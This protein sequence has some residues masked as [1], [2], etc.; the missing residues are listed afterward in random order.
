MVDYYCNMWIQQSEV[1]APLTHLTSANIKFE[2][3]NVEQMAFD[4]IK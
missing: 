2:W 3:T 1:L 4:K